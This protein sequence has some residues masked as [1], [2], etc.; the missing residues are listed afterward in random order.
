MFLEPRIDVRT[1]DFS[2]FLFT[3]II[4]R[5]TILI[6]IFY[7][8]IPFIIANYIGYI[9]SGIYLL[10]AITTGGAISKWQKILKEK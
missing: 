4:M 10:I 7:I 6:L 5:K 2:S 3:K 8:L 9:S 1:S